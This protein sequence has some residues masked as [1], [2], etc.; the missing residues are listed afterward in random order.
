[1]CIK[2]G[3]NNY[4][5]VTRQHLQ[6]DGESCGGLIDCENQEISLLDKLSETQRS[7]TLL[8]ELLHAVIFF[9]SMGND[10]SEREV[11]ALSNILYLVFINNSSWIK[12]ASDD[13]VFT[14][15]PNSIQ[16]GYTNYKVDVVESIEVD[17][18]DFTYEVCYTEELIL[19]KKRRPIVMLMSLIEAVISASCNFCQID[20]KSDFA[21]MRLAQ[22]FTTLIMDNPSLIKFNWE[23]FND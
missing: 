3:F 13:T 7:A 18:E 22:G 19:L 14:S 6:L 5:V 17:G 10:V 4:T 21:T 9:E 15:K 1:M 16:I 12:R 20:L 8:H 11:E 23:V 2:L